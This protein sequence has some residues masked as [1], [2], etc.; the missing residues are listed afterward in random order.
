MS[1]FS[2]YRKKIEDMEM[3]DYEKM[4]RKHNLILALISLGLSLLALVLNLIALA[5]Q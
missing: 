3:D 4:M 5:M 2:D 1:F